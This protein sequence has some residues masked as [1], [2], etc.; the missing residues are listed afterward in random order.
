MPL[1]VRDIEKMS[2]GIVHLLDELA[3]YSNYGSLDLSISAPG[4][5]RAHIP[6]SYCLNAWSPVSVV[7]PAW[8]VWAA[9]TSMAAPKVSAV[10]AL[11][12]AQ[13]PHFGPAQV[14]ARLFQ[15]AETIGEPGFDYYAFGQGLVNAYRAVTAQRK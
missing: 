5:G 4:G 11:I 12:Y 14:R 15:T 10:A 13:N 7:L 9:G 6:F 3:W 1:E 8:Y 2:Q